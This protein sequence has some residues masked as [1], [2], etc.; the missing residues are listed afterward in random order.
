MSMLSFII[1]CCFWGPPQANPLDF[2]I[3][4]EQLS[5]P[6]WLVRERGT[7]RLIRCC[8]QETRWLKVVVEHL[9]DPDAE[10]RMR[11]SRVL[12]TV[13]PCPTCIGSRMP[14]GMQVW[15]DLRAP[16]IETCW[17]CRGTGTTCLKAR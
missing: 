14:P 3:G 2:G 1:A 6:R 17:A 16:N 10:V 15:G 4:L 7:D 11:C 5:S 13:R 8:Q 12:R 9:E